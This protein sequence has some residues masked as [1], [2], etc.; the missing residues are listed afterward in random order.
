[1]ARERVAPIVRSER[2]QRVTSVAPSGLLE[3]HLRQGHP[4]FLDMPWARPVGE[5]DRASTRIVE[6]PRGISRH[7]VR[8]AAWESRV[9]A[10]KELSADAAEREYER[11]LELEARRL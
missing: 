5:W 1:M 3:L 4:D 10:F 11:L 2:A 6:L 7:E 8:F 9:Y